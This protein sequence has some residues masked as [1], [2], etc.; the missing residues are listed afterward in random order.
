MTAKEFFRAT[1]PGILL[2]PLLMTLPAAGRSTS[3]DSGEAYRWKEANRAA[4]QWAPRAGLQVIHLND[5][6]YLMGGRTPI[7]P[8]VLP[9]PGASMIW[10]DV[11]ESRNQGNSWKRI[12]ATFEPGH[13]P[14]RAY[15]EAVSMGPYMYVLGGQNFYAFE[16]PGPDGPILVSGSDFFNDV[17]RSSDGIT[18]EQTAADAGWEPRAG[19]SAVV[20]NEEIYV[21]GGSQNDDDAIVGTNGPVRIYF[22]DVWKSAD[23]FTWENVTEDA[24]WP[25][26][27]GARL[28][29]KDGYMYLIGGE[30]GFIRVPPPYFNDVWRT[31]DGENWE[32]VTLNAPWSARPGHM[33]VVMDD[34]I[35]LF[36]GF[37]LTPAP[38]PPPFGPPYDLTVPGNPMDVWA[39]PDGLNWTLVDDAPWNA[40]SPADVKYDFDALLLP[41]K[42]GKQA[43]FTFGG[44]RETFNFADPLNYLNVDNDVWSFAPAPPDGRGKAKHG[45]RRGRRK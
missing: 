19:L 42:G 20:F 32:P 5:R 9:I 7:D 24:P 40:A 16:V 23:G 10:G 18:W 39:S 26:R 15:F 22:N 4:H 17:W 14:G 30:D 2:A 1:I 41:L 8:A 3:A 28:V 6:L 36:G 43:I 31:S 38:P 25:K 12:L 44:D 29:V 45:P 33:C 35:Y 21:M 34:L 11:W 37:G 27:A 13:W